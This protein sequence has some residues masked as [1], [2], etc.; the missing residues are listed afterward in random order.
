MAVEGINFFWSW[1]PAELG[2]KSALRKTNGSSA[3]EVGGIRICP[4]SWPQKLPT[5]SLFLWFLERDAI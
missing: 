3:T 1:K 4:N 5:L 2:V